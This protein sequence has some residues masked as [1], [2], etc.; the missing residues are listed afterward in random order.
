[1]LQFKAAQYFSKCK[2]GFIKLLLS[3][4]SS[5]LLSISSA[6]AILFFFL[7]FC[8]LLLKLQFFLLH[9]YWILQVISFLNYLPFWDNKLASAIIV[10]VYCFVHIAIMS[11]YPLYS[12]Y[13]RV[14]LLFFLPSS[15]S[16]RESLFYACNCGN[17]I[18]RSSAFCTAHSTHHAR[19]TSRALGDCRLQ[20]DCC[21]HV[22]RFYMGLCFPYW[23]RSCLA[24]RIWPYAGLVCNPFCRLRWGTKL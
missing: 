15:V 7:F 13:W 22:V 11:V 20:Y 1:M 21:I 8:L 4:P 2:I 16:S 12:Y 9:I 14:E 3:S 18:Q 6:L 23:N 5:A 19:E 17:T 10:A 24:V